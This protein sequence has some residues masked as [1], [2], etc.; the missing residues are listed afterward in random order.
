MKTKK[1][2]ERVR[3][4]DELHFPNSQYKCRGEEML[5]DTGRRKVSPNTLTHVIKDDSGLTISYRTVHWTTC[6]P[7]G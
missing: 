6:Q 1:D 3:Q 2:Q 7:A 4:A 5:G